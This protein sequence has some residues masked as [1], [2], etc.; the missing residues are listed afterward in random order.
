[1]ENKPEQKKNKLLIILASFSIVLLLAGAAAVVL[2]LK[3]PDKGAAQE[4]QNIDDILAAS[5][6]IPELTTNLASE[7]YIRISFKIQTN[8]PEAMEEMTKREFQVKDILI[9]KLS[10]MTAADLQGETGK[11]KLTKMLQAE[12]NGVLES[13]KVD[14]IYITSYIIQ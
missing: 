13:G 8:S 1:M 4:E 7:E 6:D 9:Q 10:N 12:L 5:V 3:S 2:I 14:R 11:Q